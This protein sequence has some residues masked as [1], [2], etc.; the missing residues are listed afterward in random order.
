MIYQR[1]MRIESESLCFVAQRAGKRSEQVCN[2]F[3]LFLKDLAAG[4]A[5]L[6]LRNN[7]KT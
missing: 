4:L 1:D 6:P 3:L 7:L 5:F 2:Y